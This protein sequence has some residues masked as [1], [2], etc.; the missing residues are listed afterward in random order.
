[1]GLQQLAELQGRMD[2]IL[3]SIGYTQGH[4]RRT[5]AGARQ[6]PALQVQRRRQGP[7][8]D[9]GLYRGSHRQDPYRAA[10]RIQHARAA[11]TSRCSACRP[12]RN[13]ERPVPTV[14]RARSTA[15]S[16]A[17]SGSIFAR[18]IF[19]ASTA[20]PIWLR[21]RR[22]RA[23]SGR[24][25]MRT[26]CRLSALSSPSM[27][28]R[29]V[30]RCT[31]SSSSTSWASMTI[32]RSAAWAISSRSRS[33]AAVWSS[34][35]GIHAKRW[36]RAARRR[37]LRSAQRLQP[38]RSRK[39][40]RSLLQLAG[41][42]LRLQGRPQHHQ[43]PPRQ[44]E[45]GAWTEVRSARFRR[46]GRARRQRAHGRPRSEHRRLYR[47]DESGLVERPCLQP[48]HGSRRAEPE[49]TQAGRD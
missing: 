16:Q 48:V 36:T 32:S 35:A 6:G 42:G 8:R 7:G 34:T 23:T 12:S 15:R 19:T 41:T 27:L 39:R 49:Q 30:G 4:R 31:P 11:A 37:L 22:S 45:G 14:A 29:K 9:Q 13:Q 40:G 28:I 18:P 43:S 5:H 10:A 2:P 17:S 20:C 24:A 25:N 47:P 1:M 3:K 26:S 44:G 21:T 38:A 46:C 33:G